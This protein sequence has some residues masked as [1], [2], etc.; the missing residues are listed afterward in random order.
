VAVLASFSGRRVSVRAMLWRGRRVR[1]E[2]TLFDWRERRGEARI[3]GVSATD[4]AS[5]YELEF[6]P[7]EL[8]WRLIGVDGEVLVTGEGVGDPAAGRTARR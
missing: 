2:R 1:F 3:L 6:E 4:G 5:T 8:A 7:E